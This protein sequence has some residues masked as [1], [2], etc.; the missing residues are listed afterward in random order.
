MPYLI[1]ERDRPDVVPIVLPPPPVEGARA[2]LPLVAAVVPLLAA[3]GMWA[4]TGSVF[5]LW[6]A[7]LSPLMLGAGL[8]DR[9]RGRRAERRRQDRAFAAA[10]ASAHRSVTE[11]HDAERRERVRTHPGLAELCAAPADLWRADPDRVDTVVLGRGPVTVET[12]VGAGDERPAVRELRAAARLLAEAPIVLPLDGDVC[13]RGGTVAARA[14]ARALLLQVCALHPPGTWRVAGEEEWIGALPHARPSVGARSI[15]WVSRT[16]RPDQEGEADVTIW[17]TAAGSALPPGCRT[18]VDVGSALRATVTRG[19]VSGEVRAEAVSRRQA[20]RVSAVLRRRA[21]ALAPAPE[22]VLRLGALSGA[23]H[24]VLGVAV[25]RSGAAEAVVDIVR[26]GPHAVVVGTTG[27]GKSEF[28]VTWVLALAR[29][30]GPD[31]VVFMLADFKGGTSFDALTGLP[32]VT[33]VLTDL[34]PELAERAVR[35]LTAEVRRREGVIA[36]AGARDISDER[37]RLPRLIVVV[38][39]FPALV[40]DRPDLEPVFTDIAARGR[41][42]G[43]HLVLGGQRVAGAVRDATLVNCPLR[44]A[45]RVSDAQDSRG[46][47]GTDD[48]ARIS[49]SDT[50]RGIAFIRRSGDDAPVRTRIA[51]SEPAD[52]SVAADAH[53]PATDPHRPWLAP[54]PVR[55]TAAEVADADPA[56]IAIADDPD[57]QCQPA[58]ALRPGERG[59]AVIGG[60]RS[61]KSTAVAAVAAALRRCGAEPQIVPPDPEAAWD[62]LGRWQ[63]DPPAAVLC[64]DLDVLLTRLPEPWAAEFAARWEAL[65]RSGAATGTTFAVSAQRLSGPL[66]RIIELL[67]R[68]AVLALPTLTDHLTA[69][70]DG[71]S[72]R[73]SRPAGRADLDGR[74]AQFIDATPSSVESFP[75]TAPRWTPV[76]GLCGLIT[77]D[78]EHR[79]NARAAAVGRAP[80]PVGAIASPDD[81]RLPAALLVGDPESWQRAWPILDAVRRDGD[82][83][84]G[85]ECG[86]DLRALTGERRL[87]P[88]AR[89]QRHWLIR[90]GA[91]PTR[92]RW[93]DPS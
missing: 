83:L 6:F 20:A 48:A 14:V 22:D 62:L 51:L 31:E 10:V 79:V 73:R 70:A 1:A 47:I 92:V 18:V 76:P 21:A 89:G 15:A 85:A 8:L 12:D 61:G 23:R 7:V 60:P 37:V 52:L 36:A 74:E 71:A 24:S 68:R 44:I 4:L 17:V 26:D 42:L 93:P 72:Y 86:A 25:G 88:Y 80:V 2:P 27:A 64:D 16:S 75:L 66:S 84:I 33:G 56:V 3:G 46:V 50:G 39:E 57:R 9:A 69:G 38:D 87:P 13:V 35:S 34:D 43:V 41:A 11:R 55:L 91:P 53:P 54:L 82:L 63:E 90:R 5:M 65:V 40:R 78:A 32:H 29:A 49:G 77:R 19:A 81:P 67:P 45:L 59:L 28:L 58:V 30:Y